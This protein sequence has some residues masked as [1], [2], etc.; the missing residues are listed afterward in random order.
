MLRLI[1]FCAALASAVLVAAPATA[2]PVKEQPRWVVKAL[3]AEAAWKTT[4]GAGVTVALLE[5]RVDGGVPELKGRVSQG[6]DMTATVYAGAK[7]APGDATAMASLIAGN[8]RGGGVLGVAPE[9]KVLSIP[10]KAKAGGSSG[11]SSDGPLAR[12]IRYA[13]NHGA[14]VIS[15]PI[16]RYE[17]ERI[18]RDAVSYALSKGVVIVAAVGDGGQSAY[19]HE[20]G[21]SYWMFPAGYPG[22]VG[23]AAVDRQGKGAAFSSDNQSVLVA[24]PGTD[25]PVT[26]PGGGHAV[27]SGTGPASALVAGAVALIKA[28]YPNLPPELVVRALASTSHPHPPA[29]YDD[30][31]G[32]GIVDAAAALAKAGQLSRYAATVSVEDDLHF[33]DGSLAEGPSRP[34][35]DPWKLWIY[36][37]GVFLG[38]GSCAIAA[39]TLGRR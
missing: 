18:D 13:A 26:L 9:A 36:G 28:K 32:F 6:P 34:G 15:V 21:S 35:P 17:V 24:A 3:N 10:V 33:G 16:G 19:A 8:G 11:E 27:R 39:V 30:K 31:V 29:G 4:K 25:L 20:T 22:V 12:G 37:I 38:L 1:A 2:A 14:A 23:V 5:G 7:S